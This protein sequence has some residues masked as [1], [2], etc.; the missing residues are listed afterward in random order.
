MTTL[1][2]PTRLCIRLPCELPAEITFSGDAN[3]IVKKAIV[4]NISTTGIQILSPSF[5]AT[6]QKVQAAFKI[7][8]QTSKAVF[9]A[10]V[11][12]IES[13]QGRMIGHYPYALGAKFITPEK[14]QGKQIA[15]F[16]SKKITCAGGRALAVLL[17][18]I[19][20]AA[21]TGRTAL[22]ALFPSSEFSALDF[23]G[24]SNSIT[25]SWILHPVISGIVALG[26]LSSALFCVLNKKF[27]MRWGFFWAIAQILLSVIIICAGRRLP[28]ENSTDIILLCG[29]LL[30]LGLGIGL[31]ASIF[32]LRDKF[33]K[34][35]ILLSPDRGSAGPNRPTFTIL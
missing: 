4:S 7:P 35:E 22:H 2:Q 14:K 33:K 27:F 29:E 12:R 10:E 1:P 16:I 26:F 23:Q 5:I 6:G 21:Q 34:I 28:S 8:G 19:L 30:L 20:G 31:I 9:L 11:M 15:R 18:L 25:G 24:F 32:N 17:F 13:L 3:K